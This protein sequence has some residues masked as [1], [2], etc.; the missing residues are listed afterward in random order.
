[1]ATI[2]YANKCQ[3]KVTGF[4]TVLARAPCK[5]AFAKPA[6]LGFETEPPTSEAPTVSLPESVARPAQPKIARWHATIRANGSSPYCAAL[7][8]IGSG[9]R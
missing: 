4:A 6:Y 9:E 3:V 8:Q 5:A 2:V 7:I 1:M